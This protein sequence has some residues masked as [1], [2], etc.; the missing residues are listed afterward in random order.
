MSPRGIR[1]PSECGIESANRV[2]H[3]DAH[4]SAAAKRPTATE[5]CRDYCGADVATAANVVD[6]FTTDR[7]DLLLLISHR[8]VAQWGERC[9]FGFMRRDITL[10]DGRL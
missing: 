5:A 10:D 8:S 1:S 2:C 6:E 3:P 7:V 9:R 4:G